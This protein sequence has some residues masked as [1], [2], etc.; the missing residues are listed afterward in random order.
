MLGIL[1]LTPSA[2]SEEKSLVSK[3]ETPRR[4]DELDNSR[5]LKPGDGISIQILEDKRDA[6]QQ[7]IAATGEIQVPYLGLIKAGGLTC[8]ELAFKIKPELEKFEI[9]CPASFR[10]PPPVEKRFFEDATVL[11]TF[12][13]GSLDGPCRIRE[14]SFVVASGA[15][16]KQG[17]YDLEGIAD[18]KLSSFLKRAGGLTSTKAAPKIKIVRKTPQGNKTILVNSRAVLSG[19][20]PEFDLILRPYDVVIVE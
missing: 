19:M 17:K 11:V 5:R 2:F 14:V 7:V 12:Y 3:I 15:I 4:M 13:D 9:S 6:V 20:H 16:A 8:Q 10:T 18:Q 1:L